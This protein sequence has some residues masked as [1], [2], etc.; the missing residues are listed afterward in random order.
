[1]SSLAVASVL[2]WRG[3]KYGALI[4]ERGGLPEFLKKSLLFKKSSPNCIPTVVQQELSG[5]ELQVLASTSDRAL[6]NDNANSLL[7]N[8]IDSSASRSY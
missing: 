2:Y 6:M 8:P 1:M 5:S 7:I 3:K 4:R